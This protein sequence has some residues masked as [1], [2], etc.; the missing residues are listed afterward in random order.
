M[1]QDE[2]F[3]LRLVG[4]ILAC[5]LKDCSSFEESKLVLLSALIVVLETKVVLAIEVLLVELSVFLDFLEFLEPC[6]LGKMGE[7]DMGTFLNSDTEHSL[8][9]TLGRGLRIYKGEV[10]SLSLMQNSLS[11]VTPI[12]LLKI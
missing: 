6:P 11:R 7:T 5:D 4:V 8:L 3:G 9:G 2:V 1:P 12:C 10:F